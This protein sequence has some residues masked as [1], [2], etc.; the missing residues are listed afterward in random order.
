[1]EHT[2]DAENTDKEKSLAS[3][4]NNLQRFL[5]TST[6]DGYRKRL[7]ALVQIDPADQEKISLGVYGS[8]ETPKGFFLEYAPDPDPESSVDSKV[9]SLPAGQSSMYE[10]KLIIANYGQKS[11]TAKVWEVE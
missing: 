1:M 11:V 5:Y 9:V 7:V 6:S 4:D 8:S 2:D 10:L 3:Q